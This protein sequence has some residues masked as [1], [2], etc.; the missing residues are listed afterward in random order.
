[1]NPTRTLFRSDYITERREAR[2]EGVEIYCGDSLQLYPEWAR[3]TVIICDGPYGLSSY[4]GDPP[5]VDPLVDLYRPHVKAWSDQ[6]LP[7]STLWFWNSEL[8][9]ATV[10]PLLLEYGWEYRNCHVWD[11][12]KAHVAGNANSKTLRKFPVVTEV[13]VQYVRAV[14]LPAAGVS[15]GL[16]IKEW[17]RSEWERSGLPLSL[18]NEACGVANAATRKYFTRDHLWYFPPRD[19]F[20][21]LVKFANRRGDPEGRPYFSTDGVRSLSGEEW[22][23]LRAK[24]H[25]VFGINNVWSVPPVN[26]SERIKR[27][28]SP[29]HANQKPLTLMELIIRASSDPGDVVWEPFGGM[30]T[31]VVAALRLGRRGYA[32]ETRREFFELAAERLEFAHFS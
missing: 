8:G 10:H 25:C 20:E 32:A 1:M 27:G 9:W 12:G 30:C 21:R 17:L 5:T 3:P 26:G 14:R 23:T 29:V 13:C 6:A 31:G 28:S 7:S 11:K 15:E 16:P 22:E 24:F 2:R 19:A 4:P 18:T